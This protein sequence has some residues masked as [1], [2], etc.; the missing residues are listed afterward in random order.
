M[1]GGERGAGVTGKG[2]AARERAFGGP[3]WTLA[4]R[5]GLGLGSRFRGN[6]GS[7]GREQALV[8]VGL[9]LAA[10]GSQAVVVRSG[11]DGGGAGGVV[12]ALAPA[13]G[14]ALDLGV[15]FGG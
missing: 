14:G 10:E 6:D 8:E 15:H 9:E 12:V 2:G 5:T 7:Q 1:T 11:V 4:L 3:F 13:G